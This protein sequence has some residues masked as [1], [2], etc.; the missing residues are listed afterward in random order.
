MKRAAEI[1]AE[2]RERDLYD[3]ID[4]VARAHGTTQAVI[5]S[6]SH[7]AEVVEARHAAWHKLYLFFGGNASAVARLV[8]TDPSTVRKA[9]LDEPPEITRVRLAEFETEHHAFRLLWQAQRVNPFGVEDRVAGSVTWFATY[10]LAHQVYAHC[11][12]EAGAQTF[13]STSLVKLAEAREERAPP[14]LPLPLAGRGAT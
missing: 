1:V 10:E 4:Q 2:L 9:M 5:W 3:L 7:A 6:A 12:E 14:P 13:R 8:G 11:C